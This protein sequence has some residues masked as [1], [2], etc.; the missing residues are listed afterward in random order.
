M[1]RKEEKRT[2]DGIE[3]AC[4]QTPAIES[5]E[6]L[7]DLAKTLG[8]AFQAVESVSVSDIELDKLGPL[9]MSLDARTTSTLVQRILKG[10][11]A[12]TSEGFI[13][14]HSTE[15]IDEV[16]TGALST[17]FKVAGFALEV[18]YGD[19]FAALGDAVKTLK[20]EAGPKVSPSS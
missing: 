9:F 4:Q 10:T 12:K 6:L 1:G 2:I 11:I 14:L 19:F 7:T 15:Q 20:P 5:L 16:F 18:N 8:P 13:E 17:M 3:F